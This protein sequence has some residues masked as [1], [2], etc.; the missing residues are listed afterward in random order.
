KHVPILLDVQGPFVVNDTKVSVHD[1]LYG[2]RRDAD[3]IVK[4]LLVKRRK[5]ADRRLQ[6]RVE[7]LPRSLDVRASPVLQEGKES[8]AEESVEEKL[9]RDSPLSAEEASPDAATSDRESTMPRQFP[10]APRSQPSTAAT[11]PSESPSAA[12]T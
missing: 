8:K 5:D 6:Q 11:E 12:G 7:P 9:P 3:N 10:P 4:K 2:P 1:L